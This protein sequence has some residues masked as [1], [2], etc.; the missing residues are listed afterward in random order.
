MGLRLGL[1]I[2]VGGIA[3]VRVAVAAGSFVACGLQGAGR[4]VRSLPWP[5]W[6][7]MGLGLLR[8]VSGGLC[9]A[10]RLRIPA[11]SGIIA[12]VTIIPVI[13]IVVV[14]PVVIPGAVI[15]VTIPGRIYRPCIIEGL[16]PGRSESGR[17][18]ITVTIIRIGRGGLVDPG[19][20]HGQ[21]PIVHLLP[22]RIAAP[23]NN[24]SHR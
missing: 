24:R 20:V 6:V 19:P 9:I 3:A 8:L 4:L 17:R 15:V 13:A 2:I 22:G 18:T 14:I 7:D 11:G 5:E 21:L 16:E 23:D 10:T 12:V 1:V